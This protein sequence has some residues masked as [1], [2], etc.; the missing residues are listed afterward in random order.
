[1]YQ[2][3]D[4]TFSV[5]NPPIYS[6]EFNPTRDF[7]KELDCLMGYLKS[8]YKNEKLDLEFNCVSDM[9][10]RAIEKGLED[11]IVKK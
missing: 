8:K 10:I 3:I 2:I 1:M 4:K 9:E 5:K 7:S 6:D 11:M